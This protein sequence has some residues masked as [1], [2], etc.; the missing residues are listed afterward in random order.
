MA[1]NCWVNPMGIVAVVIGVGGRAGVA[2]R[3]IDDSVARV[4]V[5]V[6]EP[7]MLPYVAEIVVVPAETDVAFPMEPAALLMAATDETADCHVTDV[8]K[9]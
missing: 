5:R 7:D 6:V 2:V 3:V 4:T 1:K 8:V 9:S